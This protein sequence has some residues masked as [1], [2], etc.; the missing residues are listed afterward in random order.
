MKTAALLHDLNLEDRIWKPQI[1]TEVINFEINYSEVN[2][3]LEKLK[4]E[5]YNYLKKALL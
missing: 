5:S 1:Q 2:K 3:R 4:Q